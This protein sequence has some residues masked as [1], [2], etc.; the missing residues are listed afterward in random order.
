MH[1]KQLQISWLV[2][3]VHVQIAQESPNRQKIEAW[4]LQMNFLR[5]K[6]KRR[7]G[8]IRLRQSVFDQC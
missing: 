6:Q 4:Q 2:L 3:L 1:V 8:N 5:L 7:R